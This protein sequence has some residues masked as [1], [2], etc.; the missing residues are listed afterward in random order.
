MDSDNSLKTSYLV[1]A[2]NIL[3]IN[4]LMSTIRKHDVSKTKLSFSVLITTPYAAED[5]V[6]VFEVISCLGVLLLWKLMFN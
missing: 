5:D 4:V 2:E 6:L 1:K 3:V